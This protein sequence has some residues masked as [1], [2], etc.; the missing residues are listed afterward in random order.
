MRTIHISKRKASMLLAIIIVVIVSLSL[1]FGIPALKSSQNIEEKS[2]LAVQKIFSLDL[3]KYEINVSSRAVNWSSP[4][5][6]IFSAYNGSEINDVT[7]LLK[8][9][10]ST[11]N[12]NLRFVNGT[13]WSIMILQYGNSSV[14]IYYTNQLPADPLQATK[15][16]LQRAQEYYSDSTYLKRMSESL[17]T[18][19]GL[20][21]FNGTIEDFKREAT[22]HIQL[23]QVSPDS[24]YTSTSTTLS[25]V[26][27]FDNVTAASKCI[28]L[29]SRDGTFYGFTNGWQL[30]RLDSEELLIS[31]DQAVNIALQQLNNASTN[32]VELRNQP[33]TAKL[34]LVAKEPFELHP[35]WFVDLP[36]SSPQGT[37]YNQ[38]PP[39]IHAL[40]EWQV[41]IWADTGEI[42]YSHPA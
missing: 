40:T 34:F 8:T 25:F 35:F 1:L 15:I 29:M 26:F 37:S 32:K 16:L 30:F 4:V 38:V 33:I 7:C 14:P 11:L 19:N 42:L 36:L 17:Q 23:E 31:R 20:E 2:I 18:V 24:Y 13:L 41:G 27:T 12:V 3:S 22:S 21:E 5:S 28:T 39:G 10:E 9:N 6:S